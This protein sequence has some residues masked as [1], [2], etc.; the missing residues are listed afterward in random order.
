[1]PIRSRATAAQTQALPAPANTI[2]TAAA[3]DVAAV[4]RAV[5]MVRSRKQ[6]DASEVKKNISDPAAKKLVEWVILRSDDSGADFSRYAAFITANPQ[7]PSIV[8]LAPQGRSR[9]FPGARRPTRRCRPISPSTRR[10]RPRDASHCARALLA[11][12]NRKDAEALVR[13]AWRYDGFSQDVEN[14][15]IEA[16]RRMS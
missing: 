14:R 15:V 7:W 13:E 9:R 8:T 16:V 5:E 3:I 2:I 11:A 12:G 1:M 10:S 6:T 4:K